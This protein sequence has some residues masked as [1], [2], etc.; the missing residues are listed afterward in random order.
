MVVG[1]TALKIELCWVAMQQPFLSCNAWQ[2]VLS[3]YVPDVRFVP[4]VPGCFGEN[5]PSP[6]L[7]NSYES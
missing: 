7:R 5:M 6:F 1:E 3:T 2:G 4:L